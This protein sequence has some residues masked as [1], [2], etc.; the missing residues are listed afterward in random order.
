MKA[1]VIC[2]FPDYLQDELDDFLD[3]KDNR[4]ITIVK[5]VQ[6]TYTDEDEDEDEDTG[7]LTRICMTIFYEN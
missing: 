1:F 6:S 7:T 5:V 4:D 3:K 2:N